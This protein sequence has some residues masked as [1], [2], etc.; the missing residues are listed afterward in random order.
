MIVVGAGRLGLLIAQALKNTG[1]DLKVV[2]RRPEPAAILAGW[3]IRRF[4]L[5]R[6]KVNWRTS[7]WK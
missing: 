6:S 2:V 5:M 3:G 7:S 4:I 1:C